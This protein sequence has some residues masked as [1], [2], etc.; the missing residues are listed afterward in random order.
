[1]TQDDILRMA[2]DADAFGEH[3]TFYTLA[4]KRPEVFDRFAA[5]VAASEREARQAAQ[6]Q[7]AELQERLNRADAERCAAV[8]AERD[9]CASI[10][11]GIGSG[12]AGRARLLAG[13]YATHAAGMRDGSNECA[14]AIRARGSQ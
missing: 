14:V 8:L 10:C 3:G 12:H 5:I 13:Q 6:L 2:L 9:E 11:K 4:Q 7:V 1:M